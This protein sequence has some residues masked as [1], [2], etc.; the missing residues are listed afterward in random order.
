[1][2]Q[3][4]MDVQRMRYASTSEPLTLR[5]ATTRSTS[6]RAMKMGEKAHTESQCSRRR[7]LWMDEEH[8]DES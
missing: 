7:G 6:L 4:T 8:G 1:M 2:F 3:A 5:N